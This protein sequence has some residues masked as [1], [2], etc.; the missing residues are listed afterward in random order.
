VPRNLALGASETDPRC[1]P[2]CC[3]AT[4]VGDDHRD[5]VG[6]GRKCPWLGILLVETVRRYSNR[7]DGIVVRI[8]RGGET[9]A[10]INIWR[11][12][13]MGDDRITWNTDWRSGSSGS[14][15]G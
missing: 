1:V 5:G 9:V 10:G 13:L 2:A 14:F 8:E 15:N 7:D 4:R 3:C 11:R 6:A 12:P